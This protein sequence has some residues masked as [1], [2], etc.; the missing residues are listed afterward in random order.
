M[1]CFFENVND[2]IGRGFAASNFG[3]LRGLSAFIAHFEA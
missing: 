3:G 2:M 1:K